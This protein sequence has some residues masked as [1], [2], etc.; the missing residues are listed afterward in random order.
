MKVLSRVIRVTED[1]WEYEGDQRHGEILVRETGMTSSKGA[2]TPGVDYK[3]EEEE[4]SQKELDAQDSTMYRGMAARSNYMSLDRMDLAYAS[5]EVSRGMSKPTEGDLQKIMRIGK[6]VKS[7]PR[8]VQRFNWQSSGETLR[9]YTDS[10][11]AG[12]RK[13]RKSTSRRG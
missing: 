5:K 3:E 2:A 9:V 6:Y 1:G 4:E 7:H 11:W 13:T 12:C 10:D 8:L